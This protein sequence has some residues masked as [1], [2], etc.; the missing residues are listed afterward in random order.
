MVVFDSSNRAA[1]TARIFVTGIL[2]I[3]LGSI[4]TLAGFEAG[5]ASF[6][7]AEVEAGADLTD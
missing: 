7:G 4:T 6:A 5:L 3:G 2:V 1:I